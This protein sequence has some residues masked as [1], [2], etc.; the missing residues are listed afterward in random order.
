M[1]IK[2]ETVDPGLA[3]AA[4]VGR[5]QVFLDLLRGTALGES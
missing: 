3:K 2:G 4:P 5:T 1:I